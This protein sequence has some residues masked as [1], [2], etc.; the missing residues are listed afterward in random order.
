MGNPTGV[1]IPSSPLDRNDRSSSCTSELRWG[2]R[3]PLA[4]RLPEAG[5]I[6]SSRSKFPRPDSTTGSPSRMASNSTGVGTGLC[7][8]WSSAAQCCDVLAG[9]LGGGRVQRGPAMVRSSFQSPAWF[10]LN[11]GGKI[12]E[13]FEI[14]TS[15]LL[16]YSVPVPAVCRSHGVP[17]ASTPTG[18]WF[19]LRDAPSIWRTGAR[20]P[21]LPSST[22]TSTCAV[23][24]A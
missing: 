22:L 6:T 21:L 9:W 11:G 8:N 14:Q 15:I 1:R 10:V 12:A 4:S 19:S 23:P 2:Q 24:T 17:C 7:A 20:P 5:S 18:A 3:T 16:L 13:S